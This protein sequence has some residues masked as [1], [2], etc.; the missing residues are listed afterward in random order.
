MRC[1]TFHLLNLVPAHRTFVKQQDL[2]DEI[3]RTEK[4][5]RCSLHELFRFNQND[6]N[7]PQEEKK[8]NQLEIICT[9]S[10]SRNRKC[11]MSIVRVL[12]VTIA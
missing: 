10:H 2:L 12:V 4:R 11:E 8:K 7:Y 5:E 3:N 9:N 1:M 6:K